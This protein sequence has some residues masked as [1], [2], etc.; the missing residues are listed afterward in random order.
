MSSSVIRLHCMA[1]TGVSLP[2]EEVLLEVG[3][4]N[5]AD[6]EEAFDCEA[7]LVG[8]DVATEEHHFY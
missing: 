8:A 2:T 1:L 6:F 7:L 3:H 4:K 5:L